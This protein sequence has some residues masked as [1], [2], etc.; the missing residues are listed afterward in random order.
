MDNEELES[1]TIDINEKYE[2][3]IED[4]KLRIEINNDEINLY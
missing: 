3:K 2:I 4:N 1:E